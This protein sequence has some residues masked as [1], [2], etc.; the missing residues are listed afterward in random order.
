LKVLIYYDGY[1][2]VFRSSGPELIIEA[3]IKGL[4]HKNL[5]LVLCSYGKAK[6]V[7]HLDLK[8]H[9]ILNLVKEFDLV[10]F[11][12]LPNFIPNFA[13]L[14]TE[15]SYTNYLKPRLLNTVFINK[16]QAINYGSKNYIEVGLD[17]F[18]YHTNLEPE[19]YIVYIYDG[20]YKN[21]NN[22]INIAKANNESILV[23]GLK[24][25]WN[26]YEKLSCIEYIDD[27]QKLEILSKAKAILNLTSNLSD[28]PI[29]CIQALAYGTPLI[30]FKNIFL[31]HKHKKGLI[32]CDTFKDFINSIELIKDIDRA[33]LAAYFKKLY[34]Y[35]IMVDKYLAM[36]NLIS[37]NGVL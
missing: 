24:V 4:K 26:N 35:E 31:E 11:N 3:L 14:Y 19:N 10:H 32:Y 22:A 9:N 6:D 34:S 21:C 20:N 30:L 17:F 36:Y 28:L 8:N 18:N 5:D 23:L 2:P 25:W 15:Y 16:A 29:S 37:K 1:I 13:Y 27:E 12:S 7:N 33:E